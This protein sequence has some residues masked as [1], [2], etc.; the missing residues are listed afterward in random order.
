MSPGDTNQNFS[1]VCDSTKFRKRLLA[2]P[3]LT[4]Q[5]V[6]SIGQSLESAHY[7]SKEIESSL[8]VLLNL[9][10]SLTVRKAGRETQISPTRTLRLPPN[11][12]ADAVPKDTFLPSAVVPKTIHVLNVVR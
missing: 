9:L 5:K 1:K 11:P 8:L 4:L 6:V 12:V 7:Q 3:G 10:I 2:E